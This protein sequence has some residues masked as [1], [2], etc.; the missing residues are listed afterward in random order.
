MGSGTSRQLLDFQAAFHAH[1][2]NAPIQYQPQAYLSSLSLGRRH[3]FGGDASSVPF[4][5]HDAQ[6]VSG[7]DT[8]QPRNE[9]L[10]GGQNDT[11]GEASNAAIGRE[12]IVKL[13]FTALCKDGI[14]SDRKAKSGAAGI[15]V[16]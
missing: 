2:C 14:S 10:S 5:L 3:D 9:R 16:A 1:V 15:A 8:A 12:T 7:L 11:R 4:R 13:N 6:L